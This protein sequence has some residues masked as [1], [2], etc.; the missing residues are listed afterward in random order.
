MRVLEPR[1]R[2]ALGYEDAERLRADL[3]FAAV[4]PPEPLAAEGSTFGRSSH[5]DQLGR[6]HGKIVLHGETIPIDCISMRDRTWGRRPENR[7]RQAAYVTAAADADH[8]FLAV[9]N[10]RPEGEV[11]AYGFLRRE[12]V[13]AAL[14]EGTRVTE[15]DDD[16]GWITQV[17]LAARDALGRTLNATG[18]AVS[19]IVINRHTFIDINSR[20]RWEMDGATGWGEDQD[21]WPVHRW[22]RVRREGTGG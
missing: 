11:I 17:R 9:T 14:V 3:T 21:M 2:Y 18:T 4:M 8:G 1:M 6:V 13:T 12:G 5:F 19:R 22:S 16:H 20:V 10:V 7:P 15:R